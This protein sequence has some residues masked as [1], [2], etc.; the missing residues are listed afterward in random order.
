M[1]SP[2]ARSALLHA[3]DHSAADLAADR[4]R[5]LEAGRA[6][7]REEI[8]ALTALAGAINRNVREWDARL[9]PLD[10]DHGFDARRAGTLILE[11]VFD[12]V[13]SPE[14]WRVLAAALDLAESAA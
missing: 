8:D 9:A 13:L 10:L 12:E 14:A 6:V 11:T 5:R 3:F 4:A 1:P 7:A 2:S